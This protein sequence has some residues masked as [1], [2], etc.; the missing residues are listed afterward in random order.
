PSAPA[1]CR[2]G[3]FAK[4]NSAAITSG[5]FAAT[6]AGGAA[7]ISWST[8]VLSDSTVYYG[9]NKNKQNLKRANSTN[10]LQ[11]SVQLMG[12]TSGATYYFKVTSNDGRVSAATT[13]FSFKEP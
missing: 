11:H 12:Q 10:V 1:F 4:P 2:P 9:T 13:V 6:Q 8:N 3:S 5:P 7:T